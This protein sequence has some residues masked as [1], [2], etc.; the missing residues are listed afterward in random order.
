MVL[1]PFIHF[2]PGIARM[3]H[4]NG[5]FRCGL[6]RRRAGG[7]RDRDDHVHTFSVTSSRARQAIQYTVGVTLMNLNGLAFYVTQLTQPTEKR[8]PQFVS[9]LPPARQKH[10]DPPHSILLR[11]RCER[12]R[13]T[14]QFETPAE[15]F[16]ACVASTG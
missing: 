13:E 10:S 5:D 15:K 11:A 9:L 3:D 8:R 6:E 4:D 7:N 2:L 1:V 16:N 14:L 12:P